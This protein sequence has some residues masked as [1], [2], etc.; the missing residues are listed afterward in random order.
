MFAIAAFFEMA[1]A[2]VAE[3][4]TDG[5]YDANT[6]TLTFQ[7]TLSNL[8]GIEPLTIEVARD[9]SFADMNQSVAVELIK[10]TS[11]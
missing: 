3:T 1:Q 6:E 7:V 9:A 11:L 5:E 2:Q 8:N 10:P 4:K